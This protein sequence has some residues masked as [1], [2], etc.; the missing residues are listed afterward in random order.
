MKKI[1][2]LIV[3]I[4]FISGCYDYRELNNM[5]VIDG[6]AIDYKENNYIVKLEV[7]KSKK[8]KDGNEIKTEVLEASDEVLA[9]A[10]YKATKRSSN[11]VYLGHVSLL[12][13]SEE[14]ARNGINDVIDYVLRDIEISN[15]YSILVSNNID[16]FDM[17]IDDESISQKVN[18]ILNV[19]LGEG[20]NVTVDMVGNK[21]L[22]KNIDLVIPY[23]SVIDQEFK[24]SKI[25][26]FDE[27]RLKDIIDNKIYNFLVLDNIDINF[28]DSNNVINIYDKVVKYDIKDDTV[29]IDVSC[30]GKI[31]DVSDEYNL[32]NS[33]SYKKLESIISKNIKDDI[34]KFLSEYKDL[35]GINDV[36]YKKYNKNK[37][38]TEYVVDVNL[39]INKNGA[40]YE[41][42]NDK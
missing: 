17:E 18:N 5:A 2:L 39:K 8:G 33:S 35:I 42:L 20:N 3:V 4:L 10:F 16:L 38:I 29:Y 9:Q 21:L 28:Y 23:L 41:V 19:T 25:A 6:I 1:I 14:L 34:N 22:N 40:I 31:M 27:D 13:L 37:D 30:N 24:I 7:V 36:Y 15:D 12:V 11:E 26:Y 32:N